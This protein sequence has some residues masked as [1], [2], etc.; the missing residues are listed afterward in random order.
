MWC[1][2]CSNPRMAAVMIS[3]VSFGVGISAFRNIHR[4]AFLPSYD[5]YHNRDRHE[6]PKD[7]GRGVS[8]L[9]ERF[10]SAGRTLPASAS[11]TLVNAARL[12]DETQNWN[13]A[14]ATPNTSEDALP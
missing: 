11:R 2:C 9:S 7:H 13:P 14:P 8:S 4:S 3:F 5:M 12:P 10:V 1:F 6:S